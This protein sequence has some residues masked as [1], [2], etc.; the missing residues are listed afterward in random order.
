MRLEM[1]DIWEEATKRDSPWKTAN[2]EWMVDVGAKIEKFNNGL[3]VIKNTITRGE[4]YQDLTRN[5]LEFFKC[6]GW[7]AGRL[8]VCVDMYRER[9]ANADLE[10]SDTDSTQEKL[11]AFEIK[12]EKALQG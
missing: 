11:K 4:N 10:D 6:H 5:Q 1:E 7:T 9:L 12:L 3:I 2:S 8:R